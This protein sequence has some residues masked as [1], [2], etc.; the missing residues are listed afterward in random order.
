VIQFVEHLQ[1]VAHIS[2]NSV[3]RGD[4]NN[5]KAMSAGICKKPVENRVVRFCTGNCVCIFVN[6][7][8]SA[9]LRQ[10][11]KVVKLSFCVLVARICAR[12]RLRVCRNCVNEDELWLLFL[13]Q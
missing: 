13:V 6:N 1:E 8:E 2:G 11:T 9:L 12:I 4:Q 10:F 7:F 3:E 5:V